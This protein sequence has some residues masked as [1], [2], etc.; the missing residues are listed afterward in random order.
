METQTLLRRLIIVWS[1]YE[2]SVRA[3]SFGVPGGA[4]PL[5]VAALT[6]ARNLYAVSRFS[7]AGGPRETRTRAYC[8]DRPGIALD[9]P[10]APRQTDND[11]PGKIH[12]ARGPSHAFNP[13]VII[14]PVAEVILELHDL[15]PNGAC[16]PES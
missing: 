6:R 15:S 8:R 13:R 4:A 9:S 1:D 16:D 2:L 10:I 3:S 14:T 7:E 12:A 5:Q 11:H